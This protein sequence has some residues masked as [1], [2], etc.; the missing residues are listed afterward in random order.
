MRSLRLLL[1]VLAA[2]VLLA[3]CAAPTLSY[4]T[5]RYGVAQTAHEIDSALASAQVAAML[6]LQGKMALS[7]TDTVVSDAESDADSAQETL[8]TRQPPDGRSV[9]LHQRASTTVS[10][11][12]DQ[13]RELRIAVRR[14]NKPK[15]RSLVKSLDRQQRKL[16]Q[17]QKVAP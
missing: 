5:Y 9:S 14:S 15:M 13:L 10:N 11:A 8:E 1:A 16:Q 17:L 6:D 4:S 7:V 2:M 3:G 12:V